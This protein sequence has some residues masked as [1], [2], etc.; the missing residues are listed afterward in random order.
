MSIVKVISKRVFIKEVKVEKKGKE[1]E[2]R[3]KAQES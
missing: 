1:E 2:I 3:S